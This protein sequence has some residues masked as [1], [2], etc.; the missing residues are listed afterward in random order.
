M[1]EKFKPTTREETIIDNVLANKDL[2]GAHAWGRK[3]CEEGKEDELYDISLPME[4]RADVVAELQALKFASRKRL[5][6][7]GRISLKQS[8]EMPI[9]K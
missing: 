5:D 6:Y 2:P 8:L 1:N 3:A 9:M 7:L 4:S